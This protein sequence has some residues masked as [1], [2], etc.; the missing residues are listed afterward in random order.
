[1]KR[2]MKMMPNGNYDEIVSPIQHQCLNGIFRC[3]EYGWDLGKL[4]LYI[5]DGD[6]CEDGY[7]TQV[8]IKFCPFCGYHPDVKPDL[9]S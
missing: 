5:E 3:E 4:Y 6:P 9:H 2:E 7:S 1:M 8:E